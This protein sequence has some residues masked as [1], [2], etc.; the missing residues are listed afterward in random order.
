MTTPCAMSLPG[1]LKLTL[2]TPSWVLATHMKRW[3]QSYLDWWINLLCQYTL[4]L[5]HY[6]LSFTNKQKCYHHKDTYDVVDAYTN[7]VTDSCV[8][9]LGHIISKLYRYAFVLLPILCFDLLHWFI[10]LQIVSYFV[11]STAL[12]CQLTC[13]C[14]CVQLTAPHSTFSYDRPS[15]I[16]V[17]LE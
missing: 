12:C 10:W 2:W 8:L 15:T 7:Y 11:D 16:I 5:R 1:V 4:C 6:N 17:P 14:R 9:R 13:R 3:S